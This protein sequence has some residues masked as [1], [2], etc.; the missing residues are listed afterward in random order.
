MVETSPS[1]AGGEG[2]IPRQGDGI[3]HA[4]GPKTEALNRGNIVTDSAKTLK[5]VHI[6]K[7]EKVKKKKENEL[8]TFN[9][10]KHLIIT[11]IALCN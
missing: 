5:M 1:N 10:L 8:F 4:L 2:S 11:L 6:K 3:P 7:K 9:H